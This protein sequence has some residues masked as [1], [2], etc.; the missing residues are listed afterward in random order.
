MRNSKDR[1]WRIKMYNYFQIALEN[2]LHC[3]YHLFDALDEN[4]EQA[5]D[6]LLETCRDIVWEMETCEKEKEIW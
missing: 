2:L 3:Q 5:R 1:L 4:E 6:D